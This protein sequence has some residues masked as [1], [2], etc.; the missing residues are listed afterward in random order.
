MAFTP[1]TRQSRSRS[2]SRSG[3][4]ASPLAQASQGPPIRGPEEALGEEARR[5]WY[6][7]ALQPSR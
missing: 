4:K 5:Q 3:R 7:G 2:G 6:H 1:L